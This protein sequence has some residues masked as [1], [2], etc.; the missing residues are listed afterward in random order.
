M[1]EEHPFHRTGC[2]AGCCGDKGNA[3]VGGYASEC[4]CVFVACNVQD[5]KNNN[6]SFTTVQC[7]LPYII[8]WSPFVLPLLLAPLHRSP[9][10]RALRPSCRSCTRQSINLTAVICGQRRKVCAI[11]RAIYDVR[12]ATTTATA[13]A[14]LPHN[15]SDK[16]EY[17]HAS[18]ARCKDLILKANTKC[19]IDMQL[20]RF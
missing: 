12:G 8:K 17:W 1:I 13:T 5:N 20:L 19:T 10:F 3:P 16:A 4:V 7:L 6:K 14:R 11:C 2:S 18:L 9:S 15:Y